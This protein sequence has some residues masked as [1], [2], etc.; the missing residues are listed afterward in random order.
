MIGRFDDLPSDNEEGAG[1]GLPRLARLRLAL[2]L[3]MMLG[4]LG[5]LG[6]RMYYLTIVRGEYFHELS[7]NNFLFERPLPAIRGKILT[8]DGSAAAQNLSYYHVLMSPFRMDERAVRRSVAEVASL[9]ARPELTARAD[10]VLAA[11]P[12][13]KRVTIVDY[14]DHSA[15][16][17]ILERLAQLPGVLVERTSVRYYP[18]GRLLGHITG[19]VGPIAPGQMEEYLDRG[20][21]RTDL[22]GKLGIERQYEDE[23]NGER[24]AEVY[25]RDAAG[26]P[27]SSRIA[28]RAQAGHDVV[29]T[30]DLNL[31]RMAEA[32]LKGHRGLAIAM[33]PRD[34]SILAL[35]ATPGY[36]PNYPRRGVADKSAS[37]YNNVTRSAYAPAST[38]KIVTAAAGLLTGHKASEQGDCP[39]MYFLEG[40]E[41]PFF[42]D[43]RTGHGTLDMTEA[44]E[45]SCNVYFFRWADEIGKKGVFEAALAFG[46]GQI[47]GIDLPSES[48]GVLARP[49]ID[50]IY[51]GSLIQMG[52][53]QGSLI[54]STPLQ[55][56]NAYAAL[57]NG[58]KRYRPHLLKEIRSQDGGIVRRF[59]PQVQ[60]ELPLNA[61]QRKIL[62]EAFRRVVQEPGGT[63]YARDFPSS[64]H[65]AGK[66][67]SA[68]V[69]GQKLTNGWFVGFAPLAAPEFIALALVEGEGHG[70]VSAAPIVRELMSLHFNPPT[71]ENPLRLP[72]E[73]IVI[74]RI[75]PESGPP[76]ENLPN[77]EDEEVP[78]WA[79]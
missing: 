42:C 71:P 64:W 38:F 10:V 67:G 57:A 58:G 31:Q 5:L 25:V 32:L 66:T 76:S 65:A 52:I 27:R 9:L 23:L 50:R 33:D 30:L 54:G 79:R 24:G 14:L 29:L 62:M 69:A 16:S 18:F 17:P 2:L 74:P 73:G 8:A 77:W 75:E 60:G 4:I 37:S 22:V 26:R 51:Q 36:D 44:I 35:S 46:F 55:L 28:R 7:E 63:A 40:I 61:E 34:G 20:Y 12:S 3:A 56:I 59:E 11:V 53:G 68:E 41:K 39:G 15:A 49:G 13:W 19:Y 47:T 78:F 21:V 72:A 70:G 43:V 45:Q 6:A 1:R 48:A